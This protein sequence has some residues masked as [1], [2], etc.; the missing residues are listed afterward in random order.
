MELTKRNAGLLALVALA[1]GLV[2]V[3]TTGCGLDV[4][5][6][7]GQ[8]EDTMDRDPPTTNV[9]PISDIQLEAPAVPEAP[10][11]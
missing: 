1:V 2:G 5:S 6:S 3:A 9:V 8:P 4:P 11:R 7:I 10:S